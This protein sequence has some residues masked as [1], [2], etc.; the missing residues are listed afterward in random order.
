MSRKRR[1]PTARRGFSLLELMVALAISALLLTAALVALDASFR[2]YRRTTEEAATHTTARIA[3]HR[4]LALVRT[5]S[6]FGPLPTN[7]LDE[8]LESEYL[9]VRTPDGRWVVIRWDGEGERLLIAVDSSDG[10]PGTP[11]VLLGGVEPQFHADGSPILPFRIAYQDGWRVRR[12]TVDLSIQPDDDIS[13]SI[14]HE[15]PP[16]IRLVGSASPRSIAP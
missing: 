4:L 15:P 7:P 13:T 10:D 2:A 6:D 8:E 9:E 16:P 12:V 11:H 1:I 3:M 5:G 14:A